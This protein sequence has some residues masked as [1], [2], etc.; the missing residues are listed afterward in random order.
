MNDSTVLRKAR[1]LI[2]TT[3][4]TKGTFARNKY[5]HRVDPTSP[6][7]VK[8]CVL[9]AIHNVLGVKADAIHG[10]DYPRIGII[11]DHLHATATYRYGIVPLNDHMDTTPNDVDAWFVK[12]IRHARRLEG[13]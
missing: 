7:A 11:S 5:R 12:A 9:G 13:N 8:F 6:S 2:A 1:K 3:G 10:S 4:H